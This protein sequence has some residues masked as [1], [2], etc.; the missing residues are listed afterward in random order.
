MDVCWANLR[1]ERS[2]LVQPEMAAPGSLGSRKRDATGVI[3]KG[4]TVT[5]A[6][7]TP[8][9][10]RRFGLGLMISA[11]TVL[12]LLIAPAGASADL[13]SD[14]TRCKPGNRLPQLRVVTRIKLLENPDRIVVITRYFNNRGTSDTGNVRGSNRTCKRKQIYTLDGGGAQGAPGIAGS[15]GTDGTQGPEGPQG[16]TG[17]QGEQGATGEQGEQGETGA[18][19]AQGEQGETGAT[20]AQGE[21]GATGP[22]GP[23]GATGAEGAQGPPGPQGPTGPAGA[24]GAAGANGDDGDD[25]AQGA[26]GPQG[27]QG[28]TGA[29][30][31]AGPAGATGATGATG[32]S[33]GPMI[34]G[35]T[36]VQN[37]ISGDNYLAPWYWTSPTSSPQNVSVPMVAGTLSNVKVVVSAAP[38]TSPRQWTFHVTRNGANVAGANCVIAGTA[39]QCDIPGSVTYTN[40]QTF[41]IFADA[42]SNQP[43]NTNVAYTGTYTPAP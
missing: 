38:G 3:E 10:G 32:P 40:G 41:D 9:T 22:Q 1:P 19:G 35:G 39:T 7:S 30:G 21:Q 8:L 13:I 2:T 17:P 20:G 42:S 15:D 34:F 26:T 27:P 37:T 43:A 6:A 31:P 18:T 23:Q 12:A 25:G 14:K 16:A 36:P 5:S 4:F 29:Q 11:A 33:G 24:T 28:P